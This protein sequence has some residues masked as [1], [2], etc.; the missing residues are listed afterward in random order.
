MTTSR[1]EYGQEGEVG[2]SC[3][4]VTSPAL[5]GAL[6]L[7]TERG[8]QVTEPAWSDDVTPYRRRTIEPLPTPAPGRWVEHGACRSASDAVL[9]AYTADG[10]TAADAA[11]LAACAT[12]PVLRACDTYATT[13]RIVCGIWGGHRRQL[14]DA[15]RER[16]AA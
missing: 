13:A 16:T 3:C 1:G 12:C 15:R 11:A 6:G 8:R 14:S 10:E 9:C 4:P 5:V 2:R 7:S